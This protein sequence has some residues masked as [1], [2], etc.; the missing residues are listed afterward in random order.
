MGLT[1]AWLAGRDW[2]KFPEW[3]GLQR[4]RAGLLILGGLFASML[5][6]F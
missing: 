4:R 2:G 6:L 3:L 1:L 5:L